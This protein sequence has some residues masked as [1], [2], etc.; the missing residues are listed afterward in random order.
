MKRED[1]KKAYDDIPFSGNLEERYFDNIIS[2]Q[3]KKQW[4]IKRLVIS[5]FFCVMLFGSTLFAATKFNWFEWEFGEGSTVIQ[6]KI[7][8]GTYTI[9]DQY[10]KMTVESAVFTG[11]MGRVFVHITPENRAGKELM[12]KYAD[13][14]SPILYMTDSDNHILCSGS[15]NNGKYYKELSDDENWYYQLSIIYDKTDDSPNFSMVK[16]TFLEEEQLDYEWNEDIVKFMKKSGK[17]FKKMELEI[18]IK[19]VIT[20]LLE[21]K[22]CGVFQNITISPLVIHFAWDVE[23]LKS[24]EIDIVITYKNGKTLRYNRVEQGMYYQLSSSNYD[25]DAW[26]QILM[27][28]GGKNGQ[29][30]MNLVPKEIIDV[31]EIESVQFNGIVCE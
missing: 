8:K 17:N 15:G 16:I 24:Q 29:C 22:E 7:D 12:Q 4:T 25:R 6:N 23:K 18:P 5:V 14:L 11:E 30:R 27:S 20:P 31:D 21:Y 26:E 10:L 9:Q 1:I 2:N 13:R 3:Y 19:Q 28:D